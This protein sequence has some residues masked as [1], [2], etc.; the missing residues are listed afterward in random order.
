L[1]T[2]AFSINDLHPKQRSL[3]AFPNSLSCRIHGRLVSYTIIQ[4]CFK[5]ARKAAG[6]YCHG[7]WKGKRMPIQEIAKIVRDQLNDE[8]THTLSDLVQ[9][10]LKSVPEHVYPSDVKSVVFGLI[11]N[12]EVVMTND[13]K[14]K[15]S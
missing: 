13:F 12:K 11:Q 1:P 14:I 2:P 7:V 4:N 9:E 8:K 3:T 6:P 15:K 10:T 5:I